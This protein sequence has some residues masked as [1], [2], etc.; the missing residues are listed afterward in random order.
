MERFIL[1]YEPGTYEQRDLLPRRRLRDEDVRPMM[2]MWMRGC[3]PHYIARQF[4]SP[5]GDALSA[6]M[7]RSHA[8]RLAIHG[9]GIPMENAREP[10]R[11]TPAGRDGPASMERGAGSAAY[12]PASAIPHGLRSNR[13]GRKPAVG[14]KG[15]YTRPEDM[16]GANQGV[17]LADDGAL[18]LQM[19]DDGPP[20]PGWREGGP[21]YEPFKTKEDKVHDG[22]TDARA[23]GSQQGPEGREPPAASPGA[24]SDQDAAGGPGEAQQGTAEQASAGREPQQHGA[25]GGGAEG[26]ARVPRKGRK[27]RKPPAAQG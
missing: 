26:Q 20:P 14:A 21:L 19:Y 13:L 24:E 27:P 16:L 18:V 12:T 11:W 15:N 5:R 22:A 3:N 25:G 4:K 2:L 1:D 10:K 7:V 17:T 6:K 9:H 23:E 8:F